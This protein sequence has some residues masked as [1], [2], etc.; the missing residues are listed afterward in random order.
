MEKHCWPANLNNAS[1]H[2]DNQSICGAAFFRPPRFDRWKFDM[3]LVSLANPP[4]NN[5]NM[6]YICGGSGGGWM[7][8]WGKHIY[9][10]E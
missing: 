6:F 5:L 1:H 4:M 8:G 9:T 10:K 3:S 7:D 2:K